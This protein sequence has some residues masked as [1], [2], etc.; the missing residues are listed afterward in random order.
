M[1]QPEEA[2]QPLQ[3]GKAGAGDVAVVPDEAA[4]HEAVA[5][6]DPGLIVLAIRAPRVKRIPSRR[7]QATRHALGLTPDHAAG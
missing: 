2:V 3:D 5:L 7:H 6:L 4:D 1:V